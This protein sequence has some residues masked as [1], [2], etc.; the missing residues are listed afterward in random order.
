MKT[1]ST[2]VKPQSNAQISWFEVQGQ[3]VIQ[4]AVLRAQSATAKRKAPKPEEIRQVALQLC[5]AH[6][7]G[8]V[9]GDLKQENIITLSGITT[10]T[11]W[12]QGDTNPPL[13]N[14]TVVHPFDKKSHRLSHLSDRMALLLWATNLNR[15]QAI[16]LMAA[17]DWNTANPN[18]FESFI[19]E[20]PTLNKH[21]NILENYA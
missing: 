20:L 7:K 11:G 14:A 5:E 19:K 6:K 13:K 16:C 9:H 3:K 12:P 15:Y 2:K 10:L 1:I 8:L 4:K 18:F 17:F 21:K